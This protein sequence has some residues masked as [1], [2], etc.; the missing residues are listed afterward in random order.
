SQS[1][2]TSSIG[3]HRVGTPHMPATTHFANFQALQQSQYQSH[4][5]S[6]NGS[7][8]GRPRSVSRF[9]SPISPMEGGGLGEALGWSGILDPRN[10]SQHQPHQLSRQ[11]VGGV[12]GNPS[13]ADL[14]RRSSG[15]ASSLL[16]G[17]GSGGILSPDLVP[18]GL[19]SYNSRN[20]SPPPPTTSVSGQQTFPL[21]H[22]PQPVAQLLHAHL[23]KLE[24][25]L[26]L[27]QGEVAFQTYL[28]SLHLQ[29][30]GT[31]HREKVLESGAEA[32]RQS[33]FRTI[34]TLRAQLRATQ[35]LLDQSRSEQSA[36]KANWI[37]HISD[38]REKLATLREQRVGWE[39]REKRMKAEVEDLEERLEKR[40]REVEVGGRE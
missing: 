28:K 31:L 13:G 5:Q 36:T 16:G 25:E 4:S 33:S 32:E 19:P 20:L 23:T 30:M 15:M 40:G 29:H 34:R 26:V 37:A 6:Q 21:S 11:G 39:V 38:L 10:H 8:L 35:S 27:L 7:P 3:H 12:E 17:M 24:T 2:P 9:R 1:S 18:L 22:L 14:S